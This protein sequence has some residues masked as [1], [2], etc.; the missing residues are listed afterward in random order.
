MF[1]VIKQSY[2]IIRTHGAD[3]LPL[4]ELCG[5]VAY[6]SDDKITPMSAPPF[7]ERIINLGHESVI[8]HSSLTVMFVCSR[9]ITHELVRHRL[10]S[11]TQESQRYCDYTKF[12]AQFIQPYFLDEDILGIWD[13]AR[14]G[15]SDPLTG[16]ASIW[17]FALDEA[18]RAYIRLRHS[19]LP[20]QAAR[21]VLPNSC[22]TRIAVT[23]NLREWRH[24]LKLRT[25]A[26][27]HPSMRALMTPLLLELQ[28]LYPSLFSDIIPFKE[29][30][31]DNAS[32]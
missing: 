22:A 4:I 23:A 17:L 7:T 29:E 11:F 15:N 13:E 26:P 12:D 1:E 24:I 27:A 16:P 21:E 9:A 19:G 18:Q 30:C 3:T 28:S 8:E 31:N 14:M 25:A 20:P 10:A 2:E 5:R 6:K 32:S